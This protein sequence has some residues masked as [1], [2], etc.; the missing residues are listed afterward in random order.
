M[1]THTS[2]FTVWRDRFKKTQR[3]TSISVSEIFRISRIVT[4]GS[5]SVADLNSASCNCKSTFSRRSRESRIKREREI[6][7]RK[8]FW[9]WGIWDETPLMARGSPLRLVASLILLRIC[10][11][12][13]WR[14]LFH[15][16]NSKRQ[17]GVKLILLWRKLK[18]WNSFANN[19]ASEIWI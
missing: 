18:S 10:K 9:C 7:R 13:R 11:I 3:K 8:Y 1:H 5:L 12:N 16:R 19:T 17:G 4:R 2:V 15:R 6:P 14:L